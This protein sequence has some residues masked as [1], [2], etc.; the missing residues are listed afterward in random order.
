MKKSTQ[1]ALSLGLIAVL[2]CLVPV[3]HGKPVGHLCCQFN[4]P[5]C[6][7]SHK[8]RSISARVKS[9][10]QAM[11]VKSTLL[12]NLHDARAGGPEVEHPG[13]RLIEESPS[14]A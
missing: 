14:K 10:E 3:V 5:C 13:V 2:S 11:P 4:L 6:S 8:A 9:K 1:V 7:A 12:R